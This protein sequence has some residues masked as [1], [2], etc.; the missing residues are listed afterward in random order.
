M[1][2]ATDPTPAQADVG[3]E[4]DRVVDLTSDEFFGM[5]EAG[6]FDEDRRVYLWGGRICEKMA[7]TVSHAFT[8]I[9]VTEAIRAQMPAG[10][11]AS[12][13]NPVRLDDRHVPLPD[14]TFIRGPLEAY[15][16]ENRHPTAADV[17][18]L[19]EVAVTSLPRDLGVR[20][21]VFARALVPAYWVADVRGRS[22]VEHRRPEV[23]DGVGRYA[24]VRAYGP[25][26]EVPLVFDGREVARL[27]VRDLIR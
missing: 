24:D 25:E 5:V 16:R 27:P 19:V 21:E 7:K 1:A 2:T 18:L 8:S 12:H 14:V 11:L 17:G 13:E 10:W 26:E 23:V 20:A 6:L 9:R 15:E 4:Q 22:I 3:E